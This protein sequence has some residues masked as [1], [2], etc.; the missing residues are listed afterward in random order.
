MTHL[1]SWLVLQEVVCPVHTHI[2]LIRALYNILYTVI[3]YFITIIYVMFLIYLKWFAQSCRPSNCRMRP[4]TFASATPHPGLCYEAQSTNSWSPTWWLAMPSWVLVT[5]MRQ[6]PSRSW[7]WWVMC[8]ED[9]V[10]IRAIGWWV[11]VMNLP[12]M[13]IPWAGR[14]TVSQPLQYL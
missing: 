13:A 4:A 5:W 6:P 3:I 8:H 7:R 14:S 2:I 11:G 9:S 12:R 10:E 1:W